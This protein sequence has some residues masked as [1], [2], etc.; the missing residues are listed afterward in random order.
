MVY[1]A[2]FRASLVT[3]PV[4]EIGSLSGWFLSIDSDV[5]KEAFLKGLYD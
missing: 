3:S 2:L 1:F 5:P 4:A